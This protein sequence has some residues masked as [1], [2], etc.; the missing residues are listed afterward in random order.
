[1]NPTK[2]NENLQTMFAGLELKNPFILASGPPTKDAHMLERAFQSGWGGAIIKTIPSESLMERGFTEEPRPMST[3]YFD[4]RKK[5]GMGNISVTGSWRI[6]EWTKSIPALKEKFP[7]CV[8]F[9]SFGAEVV[10]EDWQ[11]MA[12]QLEEAGFDGIELDLSCT[13]ATLGKDIPLIVGEDALMTGK[14]IKWVTDVVDIPVVPKIPASIK[15]W[16]SILAS[17]KKSGA[18][19]VAAINSLSAFTGVNLDTLEPHLNI[20]GFGTYC[21]YTGPGIK[22]IALKAISQINKNSDLPISG[23]GGISNWQ[24]ATEFILLGASSVQVCTAVMWS[25]Y[26]IIEKMKNGLSTFMDKHGFKHINEF[27]GITNKKVVDSVFKLKPNYDLTAFITD[28][29]TNCGLCVTACLDGANQA[30]ISQGNMNP[31]VDKDKCVG[32]GLC[33]Q[34]CPSSAINMVN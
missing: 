32:C 31:I 3:A 20:N 34:V 11:K 18:M 12:V 28:K 15:D 24:D 33:V 1:M 27:I 22:P 23:I 30:I 5:I 7:S 14:V 29:C 8:I 26:K 6:E 4:G 16:G 19:G 21:G 10:Q 9:G 17:C 13:H 25:G 2:D